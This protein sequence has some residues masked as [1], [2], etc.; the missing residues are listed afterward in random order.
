MD[1]GIGNFFI[2]HSSLPHVLENLTSACKN[3]WA[4]HKAAPELTKIS[5]CELYPD[6]DLV[7]H[8][9]CVSWGAAPKAAQPHLHAG[10]TWADSRQS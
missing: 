2:L 8:A 5:E 9:F 1:T 7:I 10:G 3:T 6:A 4:S